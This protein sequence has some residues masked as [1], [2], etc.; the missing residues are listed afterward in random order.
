MKFNHYSNLFLKIGYPSW[1]PATRYKYENI[2]KKIN[3]VFK[4]REIETIKVSEVKLYLSTLSQT[5][6]YK[7][8]K[9]Y[10]S[11]LNQI[12]DLAKFDEIISKNP[13]HYIKPK[14]PTKPIIKPFS[15]VEVKSILKLAK[16]KDERFYLYLCIAFYTGMRTGEILALRFNLIDYEKRL[17]YIRSTRGQ[18]G[19]H[20]P[21]TVG[22]IRSIPIFDD[23][24]KVLENYKIYNKSK[25]YIFKT[26]Y[27]KPYTGSRAL[28]K[29]Y[30][31][32]ILKKLNLEFRNLYTT[33]HTF[34][35]NILKKGILTPHELAHILGHNTTEMVFN[36][37]VKFLAN[38]NDNF[39]RD[40]SIY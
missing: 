18:F 16:K 7:T 38:Q 6:T 12:F 34:A 5:L 11:V 9:D 8:I 39:K 22:S 30:W 37:Y 23:L 10:K 32:P 17:I 21:K 36:R 14:P 2:T 33:R 13:T 25:D 19:E 1:K 26:Q 3:A 20:S 35:T 31:Q 28:I 29:Y 4:N 27:N 15:D 24:Y 40:V